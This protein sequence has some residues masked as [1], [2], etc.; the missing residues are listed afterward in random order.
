MRGAA[1]PTA[2]VFQRA[3]N[4]FIGDPHP[5]A[6]GPIIHQALQGPPGARQRQT[7]GPTTHRGQQLGPLQRR[8]L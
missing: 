8:D 3:P 1:E 4:R 5:W 7:A 6:C 2:R